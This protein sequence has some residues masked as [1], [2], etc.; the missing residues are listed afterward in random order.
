MADTIKNKQIMSVQELHN[1]NGGI[2]EK[3]YYMSVGNCNGACLALRPS[4]Q[5]DQYH[6]L[7]RLYSG[8]Q[9]FT[10]GETVSGTGLQ[11][12]PCSYTYVCYNGVW[13][14]AKSDF[15]N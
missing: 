6:E 5:W 14:W 4:P 11:G 13:G 1:T 8:Y 2:S 10:Y 12:I 15:L 3:G 7:A 9:V